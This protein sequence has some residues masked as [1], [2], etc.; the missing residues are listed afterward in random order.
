MGTTVDSLDIQLQ[1]QSQRAVTSIDTLISRLGT[2]NT[3]LT[4]INGSSLSGVANG[5]DKLS[6]SMQGLKGVGAADFTRL[7]NGIKKIGELDSGQISRAAN[8]LNALG[9]GLEK[10]NSVSVS[11]NSKNITDLAK[12]IS[13]LGYKSSTKAIENIPKLSNAMRD[14][15][16]NLSKAPRVSQNLIDMTNALAKLA[17]TGASSGKAATSLSRSLD[18]YTKSTSRASAGTKGL[19]SAFGKMYASYWLIF[20]GISKLGDAIDLSS[21]LTEVENVVNATFGKKYVDKIESLADVSISNYGMSELTAKTIASR[22]QAMGTAVG[23]AQGQMA[24]MSVELTKLTADMSSFYNVAQEDVARSLWSVFTGETEPMRKYGLDLTYATLQEWA[25]NRGMEVNMYTMTQMKKVMLRYQYVMENTKVAQ[26][27]F[28]LTLDTWA[29]RLRVLQEQF[30]AFGT[31]VGTGLIAAFK[32]F[33]RNLN[34]VMNHVIDFSETVLNALG[35]I[36]GWKF[37]ISAGGA[38]LADDLDSGMADTAVDTGDAAGSAGDLSDNLGQA[39][40]NAKKL[41]SVVLGIDELNINAPDTGTSGGSG[42]GGSGGSGGGSGTGAGSGSGLNT[43]MTRNDTILK[44]Y[45]SSIDSLYELGEYIGETLTK[46]LNSIDWNSVYEGA[47]NFGKGLADFLNGLI[48]PELF[49]TVGRTVAGSLNSAIYA[50]LSF[51]ETFEWDEFGRSIATGVN[52]FFRTFDFGALA[53]TINVWA[54]GIL[55]TALTA[56]SRIDWRMIGEQIGKS[57]EE[58]DVFKIGF[59][60]I[61]L[62]WKGINSGL[63]VYAKTFSAAPIETAL[64][65]LLA[66]PKALKAI[67]ATKYG[68]GIQNLASY[69]GEFAKEVQNS[70]K[71]LQTLKGRI[72]GISSKLTKMQKSAIGVTAAFAEFSLIEDAFYNIIVDGNNVVE[73][74]GKIT[75]GA[76]AAATALKLIGLSN[77]LT[78]V[79][80]TV[81]AVAG[82]I[83]GMNNALEDQK[84]MLEEQ[85]EIE[86]YGDTIAN[87]VEES[88]KASQALR[89][90]SEASHE[91]VETAGVAEAQMAQELADK[92]FN[93]AEKTGLTNDEREEMQRLAQALVEQF[94]EIEQYYQ[95]ETGLLNTTRDAVTDL[96]NERLK[97]VRLNAVETK[98]Q[99]AYEERLTVLGELEEATKNVNKAVEDGQKIEDELTALQNKKDLIEEY[100][101]LDQQIQDASGSTEGLRKQQEEIWKALTNNGESSL[102]D[103]MSEYEYLDNQILE[104]EGKL[105]DFKEQHK[106]VFDTFKAKQED[107]DGINTDIS[108]FT[109]MFTSGMTGAAESG[110]EGFSNAL[111]DDTLIDTASIEKAQ[112]AVGAFDSKEGLDVNSPS[113]KFMKSGASSIEG[114]VLGLEENK[115]LAI[116]AAQGVATSVITALN[117]GIA[118]SS[119]IALK[120]PNSFRT[121]WTTIKN[122][123]SPAAPEFFNITF[124]AAYNKVKLAFQSMDTWFHAKWDNVKGAFKDVRS[125]FKSAFDNAYQAITGAFSGIS[126]FFRRI[127]NDIVDPIEDAINGVIKGMNWILSETGAGKT[128]SLWS[129]PNFAG[130]TSGLSRDTMGVVNDQ[131]GGTYRELIVPPSGKPFIPEGRNVMLPLEKGTKIMPAKQ[132]KAFMTG[133]PHFA[134]G[135]GDFFGSAWKSYSSYTGDILDY[136]NKPK[137]LLQIATDKYTNISGWKS[138]VGTMA[139]YTAKTI[140]DNAVNYISKIMDEMLT[141]KYNPSAGVEQWRNLAAKALQ[142]TGQYSASNLNLL[143]MQMDSESSGNPNAINNYDINAQRGTPS[144]GLMQV[145]DPTFKAYAYP[146]Y[147]K[148]IYDPLSNM[149]AAIRYTLSRY[150]SLA[151]GWK[152][153][154]YASGIGK[155]NLSDLIPAY[156]VGGFP[157]DGLFFAN[158]NELVGRFDNG[159]TAVANNTNIQSGIKEGVKEAVAEILAPYLQQIA[160]N[161]RETADKDFNVDVDGRSLVSAYDRRKTRN[162]YSFTG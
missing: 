160:Q 63:E 71:F 107:L 42:S 89:E 99:E 143:L 56:L 35:E 94:P 114:Y 15:M 22:F 104:A 137:E 132:T 8:S 50:A 93:L 47:K 12:G 68:K 65:T 97:E 159:R 1:M 119:T 62:L 69:F 10:L 40:K 3:S 101:R 41:H 33:L 2:L 32:P 21:S 110:A 81:T 46:T 129:A 14:L 5:V 100:S 66:M 25:L 7:A 150:G 72:T 121:A 103:I 75:V 105:K 162:G 79:I 73:F 140:V 102:S 109:E 116:K 80:T 156:E 118:Q 125:F 98:L 49:G 134:K 106:D 120:M 29:N 31:V 44:A 161:T 55:D 145:I 127:A 142:M 130:G 9:K 13:Q 19:A 45:E 70:G 78:A 76:G 133:M 149:L 135:I 154:G 83:M 20:R 60:F 67:T 51:G 123:F 128:L 48:S 82:G 4:K 157:E 34:T 61:S 85:E 112:K 77:P 158:H 38:G 144:K 16:H 30:K 43:T 122:I 96:I 24:D 136:M 6:R 90:W 155:I 124:E 59:K 74:L 141:V 139:A 28:L 88:N 146:G 151:N 17:R 64:I 108:K 115:G 57:I 148:N 58:I 113:K 126:S 54:T 23:I 147:D 117:N 138:S 131:P 11:G 36:F 95:S 18:T 92:Y 111:G 84:K 37:E 86:M 91:Y 52:D 152:G 153:H 87:I 26:G 27:D 53:Q 39:A